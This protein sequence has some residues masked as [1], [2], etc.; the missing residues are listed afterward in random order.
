[1][2]GILAAAVM[3]AAIGAG[4]VAALAHGDAQWIADG[5]YTTEGGTRCCGTSDCHRAPDARVERMVNGYRV[6]AAINGT[7]YAMF[8]PEKAVYAS[9]DAAT[10]FCALPQ[11]YLDGRARC[12]FLP[13]SV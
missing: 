7:V 12:L 9:V 5:A 4:A 8:V 11:D 13:G 6:T 10:W 1:M 3:M 2:R